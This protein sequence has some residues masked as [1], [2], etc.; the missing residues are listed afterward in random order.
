MEMQE[1]KFYENQNKQDVD[2]FSGLTKVIRASY[3]ATEISN[4]S[5][6]EKRNLLFSLYSFR[7]LF[8]SKELHAP[9]KTLFSYGISFLTNKHDKNKQ[10]V[11]EIKDKKG[12]LGYRYDVG[13]PLFI[14]N[15]KNGTI[16]EF[17]SLP[18]KHTLY[19]MV[20]ETVTLSSATPLLKAMWYAYFPYILLIGAPIEHDI[21]D[22]LKSILFCDEVFS[23]LMMSEYGD[24]IYVDIEDVRDDHPLLKDWYAPYIAW[25]REKPNGYPRYN[26]RITHLI[27]SGDFK[28]ALTLSQAY[29]DAYPDDEDLVINDITA[30]LA[31]CASAE[32]KDREKMLDYNAELISQA[33]LTTISRRAELLYY[34]GMTKLGLLDIDGAENDF[35][36]CL[37]TDPN[38]DKATK[39]LIGINNADKLKNN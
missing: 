25:R 26:E 8:D 29:L 3:K 22:N 30:R 17:A 6:E 5:I 39:M 16:K 23:H 18:Q 19:E 36:A 24:E 20:Y 32:G 21:Y 38:F 13:S 14:Q 33:L 15:V 10:G 11:Y 2:V 28:T 12:R 34:L 27:K 1:N 31:L 37:E 35:K 7:C 9:N 4:K